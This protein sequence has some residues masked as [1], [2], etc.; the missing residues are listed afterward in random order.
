MAVLLLSQYV[1]TDVALE[2]ISGGAG[3]LG[4]LLK[5]RVSNT[6]EFTDAMRR[7]GA[8]GSVID[9]EVEP[10]SARRARRDNPLDVLTDREREVLSLMAQGR[11][12]PR[13]AVPVNALHR[14]RRVRSVKA[15]SMFVM[16]RRGR[17]ADEAFTVTR[18]GCTAAEQPSGLGMVPARS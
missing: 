9:P 12:T 1:E 15:M 4:Y 17:A 18:T 13:P 5:D 10:D 7:I 16:V 3:K 14:F 6:R 2:L 11:S 8:G